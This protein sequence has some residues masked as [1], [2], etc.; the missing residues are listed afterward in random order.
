MAQLKVGILSCATIDLK[1]ITTNSNKQQNKLTL[2]L[3]E[4]RA[5]LKFALEEVIKSQRRSMSRGI[6]LLFL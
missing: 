1:T 6:V 5:K 3:S 4:L 2:I